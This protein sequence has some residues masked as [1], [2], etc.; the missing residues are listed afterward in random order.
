MKVIK[1]IIGIVIAVAIAIVAL[2]FIL[3]GYYTIPKFRKFVTKW[4]VKNIHQARKMIK[5]FV[6]SNGELD[7]VV[8]GIPVYIVPDSDLDKETGGAF[9]AAGLGIVVSRSIIDHP[10]FKGIFFHELGHALLRHKYGRSLFRLLKNELEADKFAVAQGYG[11][12]VKKFLVNNFKKDPKK[13]F[14]PYLLIHFWRILALKL[15]GV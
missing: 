9:H 10:C 5:G 8:N 15:Q 6:L 2:P 12:E 7:S 3:L 14:L 4:Y 13:N 11:K 1:K